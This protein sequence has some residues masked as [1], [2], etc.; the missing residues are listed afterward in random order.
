VGELGNLIRK[1]GGTE[2]LAANRRTTTKNRVERISWDFRVNSTLERLYTPKI[3]V[4]MVLTT[5]QRLMPKA[6][7]MRGYI[8]LASSK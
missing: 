1:V 2:S 5:I 6:V 3:W 7:R 8:K 4:D